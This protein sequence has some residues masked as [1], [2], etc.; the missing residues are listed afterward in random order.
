MDPEKFYNYEESK[1][2][3]VGN[4]PMKDWQAACRNWEKREQEYITERSQKQTTR[5][6]SNKPDV[7]I[8][9]LHKYVEDIEQE[10]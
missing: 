9:W 6:S 3:K 2:W 8:D 10:Y 4:A 7:K 5:K 1:G